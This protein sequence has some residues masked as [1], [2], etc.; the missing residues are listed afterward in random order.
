MEFYLFNDA[1][2]CVAMHIKQCTYICRGSTIAPK[3]LLCAGL[4]LVKAYAEA[5][6]F[7]L[8]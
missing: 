5:Y 1:L 6:C 2:T 8:L 3:A 4:K 7:K